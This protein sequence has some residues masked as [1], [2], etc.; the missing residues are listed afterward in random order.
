[1]ND[2]KFEDYK[3]TDESKNTQ[4]EKPSKHAVS[5]NDIMMSDDVALKALEIVNNRYSIR[6]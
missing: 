6:H 3:L 2:E 1:M 4:K 5:T